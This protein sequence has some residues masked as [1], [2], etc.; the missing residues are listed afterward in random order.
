MTILS[1]RAALGGLLAASTSGVANSAASQPLRRTPSGLR[2]ASS[3]NAADR[4]SFRTRLL[5]SGPSPQRYEN[6]APPSGVE[7][8][9]YT[10][11]DLTLKAW[12]GRPVTNSD[13]L[14]AVVFAHGGFAFGAEDFEMARPYLDAGFVVIT[15]M[16]RA[17][18]G[19]PGAYTM[20]YN[21]VDDIVAA[22]AYARA[23]R[24]VDPSRVFLAGHRVGGTSA[25][26]A[27]QASTQFRASA[28]FSGS[29]DQVTFCEAWERIVPF[30]LTNATE[31]EMRSPLSYAA[32]FKAPARLFHAVGEVCGPDMELTAGVARAA[33]RDVQVRAVPGD[34]FSAVPAAMAQSI[35]FFNMLA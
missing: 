4:V 6:S 1:R 8:I 29:P 13:N 35:A 27:A 34:H 12:V 11:G 33:G 22:G 5:V 21:E 31:L 26:L 16:V 3:D 14:A 15:P 25:M 20:F 2:I 23:L 32:S 18:N 9:E 7:Q 17:E 19:M 24:N 30:D 28:S 10:S